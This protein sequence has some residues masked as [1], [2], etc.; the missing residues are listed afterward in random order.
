MASVYATSGIVE[1]AVSK[2]SEQLGVRR[3]VSW[4]ANG[5]P[6]CL[7]RPSVG[8]TSFVSSRNH[9]RCRP[10][11]LV[12]S[13]LAESAVKLLGSIVGGNLV[14]APIL[15]GAVSRSALSWRGYKA[16]WNIARS[17]SLVAKREKI[18]CRSPKNVL[19]FFLLV[20]LE[21]ILLA[22]TTWIPLLYLF[23]NNSLGHSYLAGAISFSRSTH[24]RESFSLQCAFFIT[25]QFGTGFWSAVKYAY[26]SEERLQNMA[27]T[28]TQKQFK[29]SEHAAGGRGVEASRVAS[30]FADYT[31]GSID[32]W[33][34][35]G[36]KRLVDQELLITLRQHNLLDAERVFDVITGKEAQG[37]VHR[38][39]LFDTL[40]LVANY[41]TP[42]F[43]YHAKMAFSSLCCSFACCLVPLLYRVVKGHHVVGETA[44][45]ITA[46]VCTV[47]FGGMFLSGGIRFL[48]GVRVILKRRYHMMA[49]LS[50]ML[51][52]PNEELATGSKG[53]VLEIV[54]TASKLMEVEVSVGDHD[55][56]ASG[57]NSNESLV[58]GATSS[59]RMPFLLATPK[60][61]Y[62]WARARDTLLSLGHIYYL[63]CNVL[64]GFVILMTGAFICHGIVSML[65]VLFR[66]GGVAED[67]INVS[68]IFSG[69]LASF[70]FV[71]FAAVVIAGIRVNRQTGVLVTRMYKHARNC[72]E[73]HLF[74]GRRAGTA[75]D[76]PTLLDCA[77]ALE[78]VARGID[79]EKWSHKVRILGVV[80]SGQMLASMLGIGGTLVFLLANAY[81]A[82]LERA[83]GI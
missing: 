15:A 66:K 60:N 52:G 81:Q 48:H 79:G 70:V 16:G 63:R 12:R 74:S 21:A 38:L 40:S 43:R 68:I 64:V 31:E 53:K 67:P 18:C 83:S 9:E 46:M 30:K 28:G 27:E 62:L 78:V 5:P 13:F 47:F 50:E 55:N 80:V 59:R 73:E 34:K 54:R 20:T 58:G 26:F 8:D 37:P 23:L 61:V 76:A 72:R 51:L 75:S 45:E 57:G 3:R 71:N 1:P 32:G 10:G 19:Q 24:L 11:N 69:A 14:A 41:S 77:E 33:I 17:M 25:L 35:I 29:R 6:L 65:L 82:S 7:T 39:S 49:T 36:P 42:I 2:S 44:F 4:H 22:L 56:A